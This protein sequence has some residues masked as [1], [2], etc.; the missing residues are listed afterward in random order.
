MYS[1]NCDAMLFFFSEMGWSVSRGE[2]KTFSYEAKQST[3]C[4]QHKRAAKSFPRPHAEKGTWRDGMVGV[5]DER[6]CCSDAGAASFVFYRVAS[7]FMTIRAETTYGQTLFNA[8]HTFRSQRRGISK[9][10]FPKRRHQCWSKGPILFVASHNEFLF[11]LQ[12]CSSL[13]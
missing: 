12:V 8:S 3:T 11:H 6:H 9:K 2:R 4:G 1:L 5:N 13:L 7:H 10:H